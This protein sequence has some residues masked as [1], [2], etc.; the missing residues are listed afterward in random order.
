MATKKKKAAFWE[1]SKAERMADS[2]VKGATVAELADKYGVTKFTI[3]KT[4]KILGVESHPRGRR[5][6][7]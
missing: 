7:K 3:T 1:L 5:S 2:Y 4:L 6:A